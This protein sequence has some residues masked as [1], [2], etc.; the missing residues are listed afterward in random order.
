MNI[1]FAEEQLKA[2]STNEPKSLGIKEEEER[3]RVSEDGGSTAGQTC[4]FTPT[5][6]TGALM[7]ASSQVN[8]EDIC[9]PCLFHI[10]LIDLNRSNASRL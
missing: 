9:S 2:C 3:L 1:L 6:G 4:V 8:R 7:T 5:I 10:C